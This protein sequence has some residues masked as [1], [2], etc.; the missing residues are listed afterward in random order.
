MSSVSRS[1]R[2][3]K[4]RLAKTY[5]FLHRIP[6]YTFMNEPALSYETGTI[7][8]EGSDAVTYTFDTPYGYSPTIVISPLYDD[9]NVWVGSIS[10]SSVTF[11]SSIP[12]SACISFQIVSI[13]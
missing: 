12:T 11:N 5:P 9:I 13:G 4:N 7:C 8:F 10:T 3:D 6:K 1:K 2:V